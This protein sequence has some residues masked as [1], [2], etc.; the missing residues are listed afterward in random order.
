[1]LELLADGQPMYFINCTSLLKDLIS[2]AF[3]RLSLT[4]QSHPFFASFAAPPMTR[5]RAPDTN[6]WLGSNMYSGKWAPR[7]LEAIR[8]YH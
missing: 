7:E 1:M 6:G 5:A 8:N 3:T 2:R 4:R